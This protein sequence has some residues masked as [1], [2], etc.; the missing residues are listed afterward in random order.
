VKVV[1]SCVEVRND[2]GNIDNLLLELLFSI[3]LVLQLFFKLFLLALEVFRNLLLLVVK[4]NDNVVHVLDLLR[5]SCNHL[6]VVLL[7]QVVVHQSVALVAHSVFFSVCLREL[8]LRLRTNVADRFTAPLAMA[9]WICGEHLSEL[10]L[11]EH[12][13]FRSWH[14]FD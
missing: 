7:Y 12:A 5:L 3:V 1:T 14:S 11:T 10:R 9:N 13:L 2:V 6:F 4:L 8:P